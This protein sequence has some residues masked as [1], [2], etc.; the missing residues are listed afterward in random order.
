MRLAP[1]LVLTAA[2][3][4]VLALPACNSDDP[5]GGDGGGEADAA[6]PDAALDA[7]PVLFSFFVT[8]LDT[9]RA[10]SGSE[11]GFGGD[12]GGLTGAD[13]ICQTAA[14][15][16]G[17]GYKTWRAFLS[18][19]EGPDGEPVNAI[20]RIGEG[21]WYDRNGRLIATDLDGLRNERPDGDPQTIDDLPDETGQP[22]TLLGDSHD[23][24]TGSNEYGELFEMDTAYTCNDWTAT[25]GAEFEDSVPVGH[26]WPAMSGR[27]WIASHAMRGCLPGVNLVQNGPGEGTCVGC[28]GGWGGIYCFALTP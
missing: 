12:L 7:P 18:V 10:Q 24:M 25:E 21:P 22:L 11:D 6:P 17:F 27:H 20:N 8:S 2:L 15:A 19:T 28:G 14:T 23:V 9:M 26:S 3:A 5:A 13:A 1:C 4:L 16:V